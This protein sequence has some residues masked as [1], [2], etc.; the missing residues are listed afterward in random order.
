MANCVLMYV[1]LHATALL[2]CLLS[3]ACGGGDL[4]LP[5]GTT[6]SASASP[7]EDDAR[8]TAAVRTGSDIRM[9]ALARGVLGADATTGCLWLEGED[10]R[11]RELLLQGDSYRVDFSASPVVV[12]DADRVVAEVGSAVRLGGGF[13]DREPGVEGCPAEGGPF[14]GSFER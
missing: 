6:P 9:Q 8:A 4:A 10:G 2:V 3:S 1:R 12:R 7:S 5:S 13:T 11:S 14:L